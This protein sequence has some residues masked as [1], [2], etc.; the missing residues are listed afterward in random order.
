MTSIPSGIPPR[1]PTGHQPTG[2]K[3]EAYIAPFLGH[4]PEIDATVFLAATAAII[5][6]VRIGKHSS[7]WHQ[8]T[9]R[10]DNNYVTIG[11]RTNIQDNSCIHIDSR[12]F[13]TR[14]GNSVTIGHSAIIH[15]CDIGD[16][17]FV[18]MGAI[19]MDGCVIEPTGMLAAGAMLTPGKRIPAGELWAG[20]P[21]TKM[22]DLRDDELAF[23]VES[24]A[25][26]VDVARAHRIG[27]DG[28]PFNRMKT[29]PLPP[30]DSE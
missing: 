2:D 8:V 18:G 28:A 16:Y 25:H 4:V 29:R 10:G 13:P 9:I 12:K 14:I 11:D 7:V 1:T 24:A 17:G 23:N 15:A 3:R 26:Y 27:E 20:R 30:R 22:R 6:A 5:G 19:V 21:A